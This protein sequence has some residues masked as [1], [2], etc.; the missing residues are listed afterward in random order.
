MQGDVHIELVARP[1]GRHQ[2]FLSDAVR[3][4]IAME[5]VRNASLRF[6]PSTGAEIESP[7]APDATLGALVAAR[8][9]PATGGDVSVRVELGSERIAMDFTLPAAVAD[10]HAGHQHAH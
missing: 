4:P 8:A 6:L 7:L 1:D 2:V 5:R 10:P 3:V 9:L